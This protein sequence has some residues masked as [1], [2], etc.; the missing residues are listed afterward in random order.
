ME[1]KQL[2]YFK[3]VAE[4]ENITNAADKLF[5]SQPGLSKS[6]ARLEED[7]GTE[8]FIRNGKRIRLND[9]GQVVLEYTHQ[10]EELLE[11]MR[12]ELS[13]LDTAP[14]SLYLFTDLPIFWN[15]IIP[16][17]QYTSPQNTLHCSFQPE[18]ELTAELLLQKTNNII[19]SRKDLSRK[20]IVSRL[21]YTDQICAVVPPDC[22]LVEKG[23]TLQPKDLDGYSFAVS[24]LE[25]PDIRQLYNALEADGVNT[26][27]VTFH[28][29]YY[30]ISQAKH[31]QQLLVGDSLFARFEPV[32]GRVFLPIEGEAYR[33]PYY[34]S[35]LK[36][37]ELRVAPFVRYF[38]AAINGENP[39]LTENI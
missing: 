7:L 4:C 29:V 22:P 20:N 39:P 37:N 28:N 30:L 32:P 35:Y 9:A 12:E 34:I 36:S 2:M 19:L 25:S 3:A 17:Y 10:L 13:A 33:V 31:M 15:Y 21:M 16:Q 8:L 11:K 38:E 1:L 27:F 5:V 18:A 6:L 24:N 14:S 26:N 23:G